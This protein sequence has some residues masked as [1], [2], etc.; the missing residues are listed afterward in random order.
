MIGSS[1]S[2][3][4]RV[5]FY[6]PYKP[7]KSRFLWFN[8]SRVFQRSSMETLSHSTPAVPHGD[9]NVSP[10]TRNFTYSLDMDCPNSDNDNKGMQI[11]S[12]KK[13]KKHAA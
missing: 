4:N 1:D 3:L 12:K 2:L 11:P 13:H 10:Q 9:T 8:D 6:I 5:G 7:T